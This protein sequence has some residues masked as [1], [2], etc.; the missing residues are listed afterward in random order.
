MVHARLLRYLDEVA[1][2]GSI[3]QAAERLNVS[4]SSINRQILGLEHDLGVALFERLHKRMR[5]TAAGELVILHVRQTLKEY[6]RLEV[7]LEQL[8]GIKSGI[9]H[10]AAMHGIAGGVLTPIIA[11]FRRKYPSMVIEVR[12]SVVDEVVQSLLTGD[13]DIGLAYRLPAHPALI[14]SAVYTTRLGAV[15]APAHPLAGKPTARLSD[16]LNHTVIM[17]DESLTIHQIMADAFLRSK[18]DFKPDYTSNSIELMKSMARTQGA[19]TFLSRI[20]VAED[21]REG[22]LVFVPIVGS[23]ALANELALVRRDNAPR[24]AAVA[25]LEEHIRSSLREIE[26]DIV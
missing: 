17:A 25:A 23:G 3:R 5:L 7:Q 8:Q 14:A 16:F 4:A 10:I 9:V 22:S 26:G 21:L 18:I 11:G 12:A 20:D 24:S 13:A 2:R 6:G 19:V 15:V 1:H